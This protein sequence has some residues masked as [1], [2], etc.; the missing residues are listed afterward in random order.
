[1]C[2]CPLFAFPD[3]EDSFEP[4]TVQPSVGMA[5]RLSDSLKK[6]DDTQDFFLEVPT[7]PANQ[8]P[9]IC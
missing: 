3:C 4:K 7:S 8:P 9:A 6:Q 5:E 2:A 1:M